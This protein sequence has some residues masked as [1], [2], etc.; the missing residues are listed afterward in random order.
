MLRDKNLIP[1]SHQHQHALALCVRID[2]ASP[3]AEAD[4]APWQDEIAQQFQGE[5]AIH[6]AA[7]EAILFPEAKR[8]EEL[9]PLTSELLTEHTNLR[10]RFAGAT[11]GRMSGSDLLALAQGLSQHIRK[12]ERQLFELLQQLL[13]AAEMADIGT[14]LEKALQDAVQVCALPERQ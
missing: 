8:F 9:V 14:R 11:A 6:F 2:R 5:I 1:L 3:I 4:V 7:E 13:S 12:E 10:S